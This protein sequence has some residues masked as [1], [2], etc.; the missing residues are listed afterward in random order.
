MKKIRLYLCLVLA[1]LGVQASMAEEAQDAVRAATRRGETT[2]IAS[3]RQTSSA[4]QPNQT[5]ATS[6]ISRSTSA[7][8]TKQEQQ[9]IRNRDETGEVVDRTAV[10]TSDSSSKHN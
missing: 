9:I 1:L 5:N 6:S 7:T 2:T 3:T 4:S 8:P 10:K